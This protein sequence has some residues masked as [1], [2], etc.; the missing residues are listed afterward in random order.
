MLEGPSAITIEQAVEQ[1]LT[2]PDIVRKTN[3]GK[4]V[5]LTYHLIPLEGLFKMFK[6]KPD[7]GISYTDID[8][9]TLKECVRVLERVSEKRQT[10]SDIHHEMISNAAYIPDTSLQRVDAE[11][12]KLNEQEKYIRAELQRLVKEVRS[13]TK[14]SVTT[15]SKRS[16]TK[17]ISN[18]RV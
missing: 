7:V 15:I 1:L 4:G 17:G 8:D 3:N 13:G 14:I 6:I 11:I 18:L 10:L 2:L 5:P 9:V 12:D 16:G